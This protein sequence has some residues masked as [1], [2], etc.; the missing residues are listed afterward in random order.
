MSFFKF[1]SFWQ[2]RR[3]R[4]EKSELGRGSKMASD[5]ELQDALVPH[6]THLIIHPS[7][8]QSTYYLP[9]LAPTLPLTSLHQLFPLLSISLMIDV[10]SVYIQPQMLP[11]LLSSPSSF[12]FFALRAETYYLTLT[13][14]VRFL[15]L[16]LNPCKM[17]MAFPPLGP[18]YRPSSV[19]L[20]G[21][22]SAL[23]REQ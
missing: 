15:N 18:L 4:T 7:W 16:F 3:P 1:A 20:P 21:R 2:R 13:D 23:L 14:Q 17:L 8:D 22:L 10:S 19:N 12:F 9:F 6:L 11:D 5:C